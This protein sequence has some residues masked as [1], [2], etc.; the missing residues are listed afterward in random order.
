MV[1]GRPLQVFKIAK[2]YYFVIAKYF[3]AKVQRRL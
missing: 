1:F 3:L 2:N